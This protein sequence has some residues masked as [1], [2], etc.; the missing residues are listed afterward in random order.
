MSDVSIGTCNAPHKS[1][2]GQPGSSQGSH[3]AQLHA[4][5]QGNS[6]VTLLRS[7]LMAL[8]RSLCRTTEGGITFWLV[9]HVKH[10]SSLPFLS[11]VVIQTF[12]STGY[13]GEKHY[14]SKGRLAVWPEQC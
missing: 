11:S 9:L 5:L 14:A 7:N 13:L 4:A 3:A 2:A 6:Q 8:R 10:T 12:I 1:V